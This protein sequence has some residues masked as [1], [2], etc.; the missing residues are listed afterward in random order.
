MSLYDFLI[1]ERFLEYLVPVVPCSAPDLSDKHKSVENNI[2]ASNGKHS[3]DQVFSI[4]VGHYLDSN[5]SLY[6][7]MVFSK[8][9]VSIQNSKPMKANSN[10]TVPNKIIITNNNC[11]QCYLMFQC[12][13]GRMVCIVNYTNRNIIKNVFDLIQSI[14]S[15]SL[16]FK[17][18]PIH[19]QEAALSTYKLNEY[20]CLLFSKHANPN[21]SYN[22]LFFD[23]IRIFL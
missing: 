11:F 7:K 14:N 5:T 3:S 9:L 21:L 6:V 8:P 15:E 10:Q 20:V 22:K 2:K 19:V 12:F 1:G 16:G 23:F 4:P 13:F 17:Q 18:Y